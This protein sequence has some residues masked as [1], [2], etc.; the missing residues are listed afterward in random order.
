M[1]LGSRMPDDASL[2][3]VQI[4]PQSKE[5]AYVPPGLNALIEGQSSPDISRCERTWK[6]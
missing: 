1:A 4:D 6:R 3:W 2:P 5:S